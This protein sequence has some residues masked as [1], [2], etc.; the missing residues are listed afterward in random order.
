MYL[1]GGQAKPAPAPVNNAQNP[2]AELKDHDEK[3]KE[4]KPKS[5][6]H[7]VI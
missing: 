2:F 1:S 6:G 5:R 3:E 4:H 7:F